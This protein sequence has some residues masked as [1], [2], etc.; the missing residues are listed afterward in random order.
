M[1]ARQFGATCT[2][3]MRALKAI[4]FDLDG[5]LIDSLADLAT[6]INRMLA[7]KGYP[8]RELALFPKFIGEGMRQLV[9][10]ALPEEA[11]QPE[12]VQACLEE[13]VRQYEQCWHEQTRVYEGMPEVLA[14]LK[15][16][17]YQVGCISNKA[18]GFTQ[19]CCDHFFGAGAWEVVFGQ[20]EGVP[21]KPAPDAAHEAA[22]R[23]GV[24]VEECAYVGDSGID[25]QF[26][27]AAGM[28]A[29]GVTWG[30]RSEAELR[31]N[32]AQVLLNRP[33]D[34]LALLLGQPGLAAP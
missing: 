13:Y 28:V 6:A 29:V 12:N 15:A 14:A 8:P 1:N 24:A 7:L 5:T 19:L 25:M 18:H 26:A 9:E 31:E 33:Q 3:P 16:Q 17:G 20:R 2:V 11:R 32:G 21:R 10:R 34:L 30:F 23:L 4:L 22:A 27:N